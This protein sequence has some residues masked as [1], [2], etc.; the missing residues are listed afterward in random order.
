VP[1]GQELSFEA[2][3]CRLHRP[4]ATGH[5]CFDRGLAIEISAAG[6]ST[7]MV[8]ALVAASRCGSPSMN[9]ARIAGKS[10]SWHKVAADFDDFLAY[11][12]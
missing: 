8:C 12:P 4:D 7:G 11:Q 1:G 5:G 10:G 9:S 2:S 3:H 6:K